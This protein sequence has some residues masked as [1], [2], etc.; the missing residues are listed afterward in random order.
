MA[1]K[2]FAF[3]A[4]AALSMSIFGAPCFAADI[5]FDEPIEGSTRACVQGVCVTSVTPT[6]TG[7][8]GGL[9]SQ[10]NLVNL[11]PAQLQSIIN[12]VDL[13]NYQTNQTIGLDLVNG[14]GTVL[15]TVVVN[16]GVNQLA[17]TADFTFGSNAVGPLANSARPDV[18]ATGNYQDVTSVLQSQLD[19]SGLPF[20]FSTIAAFV[21]AS[22]FPV[23][24]AA[25]TGPLAVPGQVPAPATGLLLLIGMAALLTQ[26]DVRRRR[27][28]SVVRSGAP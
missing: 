6:V 18:L 17:Y 5:Q 20:P 16:F 13:Q 22:F 12:L 26:R 25:R 8:T 4:T 9:A 27:L 19:F 24:V 1:T 28:N 2:R 7:S 15:N 3:I 14:N 21:R 10:A 11:V 23:S